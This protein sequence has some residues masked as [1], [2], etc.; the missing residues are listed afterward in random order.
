[1]KEVYDCIVLGAGINGVGIAKELS[2]AGKSVIVLDKATIGSGASSHS[3]RLIHGGLRYLEHFHFGLV[4]EA[5]HDRTYLVKHYPDLV[6]MTEFYLPIYRGSPRPAWMIRTGLWL[7]DLFSGFIA[8]HAK[9]SHEKFRQAFNRIKME[10]LRK[11]FYYFDAKTH[12]LKLTQT[13]ALQAQ[14]LGCE[15]CE[16]SVIKSID[17]EKDV[18]T[19]HLEDRIIKT[20]KLINATGAWIDEL[21]TKYNL[22]SNYSIRKVSGIH[23]VIDELIVPA[24][25]LLQTGHQRIFFVIPEP[26]SGQTLIGTTERTESLACD[27]ITVNEEDISYLL[28][29]VN[30]YLNV[31]LTKK[32]VSASYIGVRPIILSKKSEHESSREYKLDLHTKGEAA[33]LHVYGGKLTTFHSLSKKVAKLLS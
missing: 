13:I 26:E 25:I 22:P 31:P 15:I 17:F 24:P 28:K 10:G 2:L 27:A 14:E 4:K 3:S 21:N 12:D 16:N 8:P 32:D 7:Y 1:M 11:V 18:I 33:L 20:K 9:V 19:V 29:E 30:A 23:L 6:K 5:L